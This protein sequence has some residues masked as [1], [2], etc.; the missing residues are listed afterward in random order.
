MAHIID[1]ATLKVVANIL[2]DVRPRV[3]RF[4]R[5]DKH[6]WVTAEIGGTV[7]VID[8]ATRKVIKKFGFEIP[9]IRPELIQPM[10]VQFS[11]DGKLAFVALSTAN[12]IA[13]V[14]TATYEVKNYILVGQRPWHLAIDEAGEKIYT[15]NG[16]T[17][18][19]TVIDV[20][21]Q[22]PEKSITVGRLPWGVVMKP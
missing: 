21:T 10:G 12:R 8:K 19:M 9:G 3:A 15:V 4:T 11:K 16:L 14:D 7:A 17:N 13:V 5:D 22:K 6:V 18:D 1:N 20:A 2:V